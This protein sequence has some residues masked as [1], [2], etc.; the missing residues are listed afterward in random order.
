MWQAYLRI[1]RTAREPIAESDI[2]YVPLERKDPK[3]LWGV[4]A[5]GPIAAPLTQRLKRPVQQLHDLF[6]S[7]YGSRIGCHHQVFQ[8]VLG[9]ESQVSL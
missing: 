3:R 7:C 9:N 5:P 4:L 2:Q 8:G 1:G 6:L